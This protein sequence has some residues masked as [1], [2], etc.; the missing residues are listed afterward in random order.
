[1]E[2]TAFTYTGTVVAAAT[3]HGIIVVD[4]GDG[5]PLANPTQYNTGPSSEPLGA[6]RF[7]VGGPVSGT[8]PTI[9]PFVEHSDDSNVW[10][11]LCYAK[12]GWPSNTISSTGTLWLSKST[13]KRFARLSYVSTGTSISI[14]VNA[15]Y[16]PIY[17]G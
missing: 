12:N 10:E 1:M 14:P 8:T 7:T 6:F 3:V 2:E 11:T 17:S 5:A 4:M 13:R 9:Q 15:A 16:D